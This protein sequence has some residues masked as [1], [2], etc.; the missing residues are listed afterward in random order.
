VG[1]GDRVAVIRNGRAD[2]APAFFIAAA[3]IE[4]LPEFLKQEPRP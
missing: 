4:R 3:D 1:A 2:S